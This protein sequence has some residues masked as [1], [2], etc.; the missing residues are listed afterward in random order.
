MQRMQRL[1]SPSKNQG[2]I[3]RR[4][5]IFKSAKLQKRMHEQATFK[6]TA[7]VELT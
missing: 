7:S 2:D 5:E 3:C 4:F 6:T 1:L